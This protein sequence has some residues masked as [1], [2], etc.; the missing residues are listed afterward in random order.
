MKVFYTTVD[1]WGLFSCYFE[2][3]TIFISQ[4][5]EVGEYKMQYNLVL[6]ISICL[7]QV[8]VLT[9]ITLFEGQLNGVTMW[10]CTAI[11]IFSCT[12]FGLSRK[13]KVFR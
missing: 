5:I 12:V 10:L 11:F 3:C 2:K 7:M 1:V 9:N 6:F 8:I 13:K 4:C